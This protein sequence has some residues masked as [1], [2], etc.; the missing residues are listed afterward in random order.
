MSKV[1]LNQIDDPA[2]YI[3]ASLKNS[4]ISDLLNDLAELN[5]VKDWHELIR[6]KEP[7][8]K[9]DDEAPKAPKQAPLKWPFPPIEVARNPKQILPPA[10]KGEKASDTKKKLKGEKKYFAY[11]L[12][13][14]MH[15]LTVARRLKLK[16]ID[17]TIKQTTDAAERFLLQFQTNSGPRG[18]RFD[19]DDR[20][21]AI[22]ILAKEF[23]YSLKKLV[24]ETGLNV[25]SISRILSGK[26]RKTGP[27]K[28]ATPRTQVDGAM[29][30]SDT[31]SNVA[32]S[33]NVEAP[34]TKTKAASMTVEGWTERLKICCA[35]FPTMRKELIKFLETAPNKSALVNLTNRVKEINEILN[36]ILYTYKLEADLKN[37]EIKTAK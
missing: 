14:G 37:N 8:A 2:H 10:K 25:G 19:K 35:E 16:E 20:D 4:Y 17:A 29:Q 6:V 15:R 13:D 9:K 24:E 28:K 30:S 1:K 11:E 22:R 23:N 34:A 3:R 5:G 21:N 32:A 26:Q 36:T 18:I 7:K 27:R 33:T 12:I 31:K